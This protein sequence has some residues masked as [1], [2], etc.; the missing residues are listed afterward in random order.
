MKKIFTCLTA[1][2]GGLL[3]LFILIVFIGTCAE[4]KNWF[5][6]HLKKQMK[7]PNSYEEVRYKVTWISYNSS[8]EVD[9]TFRGNN[10]FG[11]PTLE[12]WTGEVKFEGDKVLYD[13]VYQLE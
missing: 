12:R 11:V 2:V 4:A 5:A 3:A 8:Y 1:I 10:S 13:N 6:G 7:D 9:L